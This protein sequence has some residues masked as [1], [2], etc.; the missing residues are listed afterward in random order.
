MKTSL[1]YSTNIYKRTTQHCN[2]W[3]KL[4]FTV[5]S[6]LITLFI[7]QSFLW[8]IQ[9]YSYV[10]LMKK[11]LHKFVTETNYQFSEYYWPRYCF[12][13]KGCH[14]GILVACGIELTTQ[15]G[16][17]GRAPVWDTAS[18]ITLSVS[19][20]SEHENRE[21]TINFGFCSSSWASFLLLKWL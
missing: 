4:D 5:I 9:Y 7:Q 18:P 6:F 20:D 10:L 19:T 16:E 17:P 14:T 8:L 15:F 3:T 2:N 13:D 1:Y 11:T 21:I 12:N